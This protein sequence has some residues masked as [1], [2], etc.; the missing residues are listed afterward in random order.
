MY[1]LGLNFSH[2][3]SA[4][5]L[6]DAEIRVALALERLVRVRRGI[7]RPDQLNRGL[8]ALVEYCLE[9]EGISLEQVDHFIACSTE[10]RS[11]E[12]EKQLL[13][14]VF[15][16]P[17]SKVLPMQHPGHHL[18][19]ACA[20]F[21]CSGFLEAAAL[22]VDAYG[23]IVG[24][25]REAESG[26]VFSRNGEPQLVFRNYKE[27]TRVA[28]HLR[29]GRFVMPDR[30]EGVGEMYRVLSLA[31][32]FQQPGTYYDEAGKT[33]GLA[34]YGRLLS[35]EPVLIRI[36]D[37]GFD[38]TNAWPFLASLN[39]ISEESGV[40]YLN[41]RP[42]STPISVFHRD[43]AAQVQWEVEEACVYLARKLQRETGLDY[44]VLGGGTFLN[45]IT[46]FRILKESGFR[47]V[48][49][50]PASTDDGTAVGAAWY[51][52]RLASGRPFK[53]RRCPH[54]YFGKTYSADRIERALRDHALPYRCCRGPIDAARAAA[55]A[56]AEGK[57]VGWFQGGSEFGPRSLGNRSVL[58]NPLL[59]GVKDFLNQRVKFREPFRP[60]APAVIEECAEEYFDLE[61]AESP[62]MLLI[63]P[64]REKYR[65]VLPAV[66]HVDGTAR[67]Q[68]VSTSANPL[69]YAL[70]EEFGR[71]TGVPVV[72]NTS[73]NLRGM[74]IVE[75]PEDALLC[76]LSTEMDCL[77]MDRFVAEAANFLAYVP[78]RNDL[79]LIASGSWSANANA[80]MLQ[81][82]SVRQR[83]GHGNGRTV[84]LTA[85]QLELLRMIDG[86]RSVREIAEELGIATDK[87]VREV[88]VV[89][90][91]GLLKWSHLEGRTKT[92]SAHASASAA[93]MPYLE[94]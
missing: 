32:G 57:I 88:L 71:L 65:D 19:H 60:F 92:V 9:A 72:L 34:A 76:F 91:D 59:P 52:S 38:F 44:L 36:T 89:L 45:S 15:F 5:L 70:I 40:K 73:F 46:N 30:L 41:V 43:L 17:R 78:V 58:A 63:C 25:G 42:A 4:C 27:G 48:Y 39:L 20:S 82:V 47:D 23:S 81:S 79:S 87:A 67:V 94:P 3:Y 26:F 1:T 33:M 18:A 53:P 6:K 35:R 21:F 90:R 55:E 8:H 56:L 22:V 77:V 51:G 10:T 68:K 93:P 49:V 54:V 64:V 75:T 11:G 31:L 62:Y 24:N 7:V 50:F 12:E 28:A 85:E 74:P 69:F 14:G 80:Y 84:P 83:N 29:G 37:R 86:R 66:T 16:L 13:D 61:G 2:D